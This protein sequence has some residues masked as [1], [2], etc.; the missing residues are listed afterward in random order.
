MDQDKLTA[1]VLEPLHNFAS[2]LESG[3]LPGDQAG[4]LLALLV[5]G[6]ESKVADHF[7]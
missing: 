4:E 5:A 2:L 7:S 1:L 3:E 6:I